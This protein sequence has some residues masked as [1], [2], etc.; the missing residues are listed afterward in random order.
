MLE[1]KRTV[2]GDGLPVYKTDFRVK[3]G[4]V[5]ENMLYAGQPTPMGGTQFAYP[6][7]DKGVAGQIAGTGNL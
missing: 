1:V 4:P 7:T 5:S 2:T 3:N 6:G